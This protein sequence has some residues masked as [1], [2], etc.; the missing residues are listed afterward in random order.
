MTRLLALSVLVLAFAAPVTAAPAAS[1]STTLRIS[2]LASGL[3]YSTTHLK[4]AHGRVTIVMTNHSVLGHD[5]AI[6]G[7]GI[8]V[9]GKV[10]AKGKT[11]TVT[12]TLKKGLYT[13][14][15][16][17]PGHAA[18]GMKGVLTIT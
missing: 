1:T 17:V 9:K 4:A 13:F 7:H 16:T 12:A 15:C 3:R 18:A 5:I 14:L 8:F 11:S 6:K 2:A 10:V